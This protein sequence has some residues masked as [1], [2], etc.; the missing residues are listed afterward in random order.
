MDRAVS[1]SR[2]VVDQTPELV[3]TGG[4]T[5]GLRPLIRTASQLVP[6]LALEGLA[7]WC[8]G[9]QGQESV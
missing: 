1:E 4:G 3:M 8:V 5:R 6:D 9:A 7:A 2:A